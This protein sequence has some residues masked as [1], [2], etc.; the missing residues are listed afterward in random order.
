MTSTS[1]FVMNS[2]IVD[3]IGNWCLKCFTCNHFLSMKDG[4]QNNRFY[5]WWVISVKKFTLSAIYCVLSNL[6]LSIGIE[7]QYDRLCKCSFNQWKALKKAES[8]PQ[9]I[10]W[11]TSSG[12]HRNPREI[13][14]IYCYTSMCSAQDMVFRASSPEQS[15]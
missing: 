15:V 14:P 10:I 5:L 7:A 9:P 4:L 13:T 12:M 3:K 2:E 1:K 6:A 8:N 11:S